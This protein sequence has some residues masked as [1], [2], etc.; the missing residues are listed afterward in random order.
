[1]KIGVKLLRFK[2]LGAKMQGTVLLGILFKI[3]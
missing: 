2:K 3:V 1:M